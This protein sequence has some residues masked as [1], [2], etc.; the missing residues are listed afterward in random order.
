MPSP[1]AR[2][3]VASSSSQ[4]RELT[5][6]A[7]LVGILVGSLLCFTNA[8]FGLQSSWIS[9]SSMQ[10]ALVGYG[11]VKLIPR[12]S[13]SSLRPGD[14]PEAIESGRS[15]SPTFLDRCFW[16][17]FGQGGFT[18][19]ENVVL[20]ATAVALG[21]MPLTTGLIGIVPALLQIKPAKDHGAQPIVLS[22]ANLLLWSAALAFFGVFFASP[23]RKRVIVKE[24]LTFPSGT[25][26]AH[27]IGVLH[28]TKLRDQ[29][30]A[31][32]SAIEDHRQSSRR[33]SSGHRQRRRRGLAEESDERAPLLESREQH[34]DADSADD[35]VLKGSRG[36]KTLLSSFVV[37]LAFTLASALF[38]VLYAVPLFDV[39]PPHTLAAR[40][41][42]YFTPSLSYVGQG[43]IMGLHTTASML[44]GAIFGWAILSPLAHHKG[45]TDGPPMDAEEGSK[46]WILW[47][48]LAIMT[49]ESLIGLLV[50][51]FSE[52]KFDRLRDVLSAAKRRRTPRSLLEGSR[53]G[54]SD[55]R[56]DD[57]DEED[58]EEDEP[59]ERLPPTSAVLVGLVA[60]SA[61]ALVSMWYLFGREGIEPYTTLI[62]IL[63]A[64]ALSILAVRSLGSTDLNPVAALGK[65][66]QLIF[67]FLQ[68]R[69]IVANM[70]AG[71]VSEAGAMQAGELMQSYKTGYLLRASPRSQ[72]HGQLIGSFCGIFV[73]TIAYQ[74]YLKVYT[75]PSPSFPAP[76]ATMWLNFARLVNNGQIPRH[77]KEWMIGTAIFFGVTG[78]IKSI[79]QARSL[80]RQKQQEAGRSIDGSPAPS[81]ERYSYYLP[82]GVAF[83][84]GIL[85]TPNFS[86][87]RFIGGVISFWWS[88]R[89]QRTR[90]TTSSSPTSSPSNIL[91]IIVASGLVLGEGAGSIFNLFAKQMGMQTVSC[92]GCRGSCGGGC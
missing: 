23:L 69:N 4:A 20:Q 82:S 53:R 60:S 90:P 9:M 49:S 47:I 26:T 17:W 88:R 38:P 87:A 86:I 19:Q 28:D 81:W 16:S 34:Q 44:A 40:W 21:S 66:S 78:T 13:S 43:I 12:T 41:G 5:G 25:A 31:A 18:P 50:I 83:A 32:T 35:E 55:G 57:D 89:Q 61:L 84:V 76:A 3:D 80:K 11:I 10:A 71:G 54:R 52:V 64:F 68:P 7:I 37:S 39:L 72:F 48:S 75:I 42:W 15:Y 62:A 65:I 77:S 36:W 1:A 85:N 73:S 2:A 59:K 79:A 45:W 8:Y 70:V 6:R 22:G 74:L 63:L 58:E 56:K 91:I 27:L 51:L 14:Q 46:G 29:E 30:G 92:F 24:K 67:A 33:S